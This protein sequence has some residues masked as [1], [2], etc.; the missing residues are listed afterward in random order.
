VKKHWYHVTIKICTLCDTIFSKKRKRIYGEKPKEWT[1]RIA[2]VPQIPPDLCEC[3]KEER[4]QIRAF[5]KR[6][7]NERPI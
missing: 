5:C 3:E 4:R 6:R 2:F 7:Q 1:D